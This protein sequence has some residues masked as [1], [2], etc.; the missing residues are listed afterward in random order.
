MTKYYVVSKKELDDVIQAAFEQANAESY[1]QS[2]T[3]ITRSIEEFNKSL[4]ACR[5]RKVPEEID[6][7]EGY[8]TDD[9]Q[10]YFTLELNK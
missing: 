4:A 2:R 10:C 5:A 1:N 3:W 8:K 6:V 7:L 9:P